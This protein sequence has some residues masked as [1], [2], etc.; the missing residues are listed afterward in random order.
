M[1]LFAQVA[2]NVC[3]CVLIALWT[4][5][6]KDFAISIAF[7]AALQAKVT[8]GVGLNRLRTGVFGTTGSEKQKHSQK[9]QQADADE[10]QFDDEVS[11]DGPVARNGRDW[12]KGLHQFQDK[13]S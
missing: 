9:Q 1:I 2:D 6:Q 3:K 7:R 11:H 8:V 5:L 12:I 4:F 13:L 10:L